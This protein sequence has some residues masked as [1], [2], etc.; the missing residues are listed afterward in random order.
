[1]PEFDEV[2]ITDW[3]TSGVE[4]LGTK[5]KH[6]CEDP[7]G[8]MWLF[9]EATWNTRADGST[10]PKGDDWSERV[11]GSVANELGLPAATVELATNGRA[12]VVTHGVISR[13]VLGE[14][15]S[16]IHGNELLAE[17]GVGGDLPTDRSGY[18]LNSVQNVLAEVQPPMPGDDLSAWE[19]WVGYVVLDALVGNTDRHQENWAVIG[20]G[21]RRL[22]PTFD[23]ASSL[24]FLLDDNDRLDRLSTRDENRTV[25]AYARRAR[26]KFDGRPHP[27]EVA[28]SALGMC[29]ARARERWVGR[30][31]NLPSIGHL[32]ARIPHHR[33]S[34]PARS[35]AAA[36]YEVNRSRLLSDPVCTL[37]S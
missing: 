25:A 26:S 14:Q 11:G 19:W 34:E 33:A 37:R 1:M 6:W 24:G 10:Y 36:L 9:K 35:F 28:T 29:S 15:E 7:D 16:L 20:D 3:R 2:D 32:L 8:V 17:I 23:H 5:P 30:V 22:A 12:A 4:Q 18:T 31:E 13:K 21:N 27:C